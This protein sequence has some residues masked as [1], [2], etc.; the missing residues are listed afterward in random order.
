MGYS[1]GLFQKKNP[2]SGGE[3]MKFP[4]IFKKEHE[5]IPGLTYLAVAVSRSEL[6]QT[7]I[8]CNV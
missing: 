5:E 3:D 6:K 8:Y 2:N 4:G 1:N 7:D